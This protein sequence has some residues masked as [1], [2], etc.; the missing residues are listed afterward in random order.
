MLNRNNIIFPIDF[1]STR[2]SLVLKNLAEKNPI[3]TIWFF[4]S[5][6][7]FSGLILLW[8]MFKFYKCCNNSTIF[9]NLY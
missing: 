7:K 2:F 5:N 9:Y 8:T 1:K 4:S 6:I 3:K